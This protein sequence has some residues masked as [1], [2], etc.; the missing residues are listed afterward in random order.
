MEDWKLHLQIG[1]AQE[2][3]L[4]GEAV[5]PLRLRDRRQQEADHGPRLLTIY[6]G[7][8]ESVRRVAGLVIDLH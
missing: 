5:I 2:T 3:S 6:A 8:V 7:I 4:I 1:N